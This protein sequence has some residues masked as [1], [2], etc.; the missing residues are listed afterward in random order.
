[1]RNLLIAALLAGASYGVF[2]APPDSNDR[3]EYRGQ[4]DLK[5]GSRLT[6]TERH[7]TLYAELD[8]VPLTELAATGPA[9]YS[10]KKGQL[11]IEFVQAE[12]GSVSG[13]SVTQPVN[14]HPDV[15]VNLIAKE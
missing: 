12:N 5:D 2:A 6:I 4:Y 15:K 7:H 8:N 3:A 14:R 1:M 11:K 9:A 10:D 13:V